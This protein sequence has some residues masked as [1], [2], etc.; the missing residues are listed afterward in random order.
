MSLIILFDTICYKE[1]EKMNIRELL[2]SIAIAIAIS[3]GVQT[4]FFP[5]K[6]SSNQPSWTF[7]AQKTVQEQKPLNKEIDFIEAKRPHTVVTTDLELSW[8]RVTFTTEGASLDSLEFVHSIDGKSHPLRTIFPVDETERD[9]RCFLLALEQETPYFYTLVE[10][11]ELDDSIELEYQVESS[12]ALITK[13]YRVSRSKSQIDLVVGIESKTGEAVVP[14]IFFP[15]PILIDLGD[16]DVVSAVTITHD[17]VFS[18]IDRVNIEDE[19]GWVQP[20]LFGSQDSYFVHALVEDAHHFANRAYYLVKGK[21]GIF[22]ILEGPSVQE[23]QEWTLSFYMGPKEHGMMMLVNPNLEKTLDYSGILAPLSRAL[24]AILKWLNKYVFNYGLAIILLTLLIKLLLFPLTIKSEKSTRQAKELQ[25]KL[26]YLQQKYKDDPDRLAI[27]RA[28]FIKK[29]GMPGLGGCLPLLIQAPIFFAISRVLNTS[30]E[31]YQAPMAW[32]SDLS[33]SDPY[34]ILPAIIAIS[35]LCRVP[36]VDSSQR[37]SIVLMALVFGAF[38]TKFSAGLALY[39]AA[40]TL[41]DIVQTNVVGIFKR[42]S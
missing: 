39:L 35:M 19:K 18:K 15:S 28:E 40:G 41:I 29:H 1:A 4:Y 13:T 37:F 38:A 12:T 3:W 8:G 34:Y 32:I 25:K 33:A 36:S 17:G 24:L 27:E 42:K 23:K 14:R 2:V 6:N 7:S 11:R 9:N 30:V 26:A 31:L 22:S 21:Y 16:R 20:T 10:K 5:E